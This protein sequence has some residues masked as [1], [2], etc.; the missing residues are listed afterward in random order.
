MVVI[1]AGR[2]K[3]LNDPAVRDVAAKYGDPDQLLTE[4]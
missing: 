3:A 2:L 4:D 1:E